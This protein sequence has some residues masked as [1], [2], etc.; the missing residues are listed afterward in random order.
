MKKK[1]ESIKSFAPPNFWLDSL[2][3]CPIKIEDITYPSVFHAFVSIKTSD[4]E[5][6][7][8]I[9]EHKLP[10]DIRDFEKQL[11]SPEYWTDKFKIETMEILVFKKFS[12]DPVLAAKLDAT[13]EAGLR[14][15]LIHN[16]TFFGI[17]Q[18]KGKNH[19]GKI[20]VR[21]RERLRK[22]QEPFCY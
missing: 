17:Y 5:L 4:I 10:A 19:L 18:R 14:N 11:P 20:I 12:E 15:K 8:K 16:E 13:G 9:L 3:P 21:V 6:K 7:K 22:G 2:Y 1:Q